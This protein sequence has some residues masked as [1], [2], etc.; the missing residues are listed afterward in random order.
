M[1]VST[2]SLLLSEHECTHP[3]LGCKHSEESFCI[4]ARRSNACYGNSFE[5]LAHPLLHCVTRHVKEFWWLRRRQ[6]RDG[7]RRHDRTELHFGSYVVCFGPNTHL[8]ALYMQNMSAI[9]YDEAAAGRYMS[10]IRK[11]YLFMMTIHMC[12][13]VINTSRVHLSSAA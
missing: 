7:W 4:D 2:I 6:D 1:D 12:G 3:A 8:V 11:G 10:G 13:N 9:R 5:A